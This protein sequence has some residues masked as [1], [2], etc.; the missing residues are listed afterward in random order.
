MKIKTALYLMSPDKIDPEGTTHI[1]IT[2]IYPNGERWRADR[3]E[4]NEY[5]DSYLKD[6]QKKL[7]RT[8][9]EQIKFCI[10]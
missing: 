2:Y 9:G 4:L 5:V 6:E 3:F 7:T 8:E 10:L 1:Y